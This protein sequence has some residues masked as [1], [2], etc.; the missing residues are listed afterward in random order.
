M[1]ETEMEPGYGVTPEPARH[2]TSRADREAVPT[3]LVVGLTVAVVIAVVTRTWI[4]GPIPAAAALAAGR[5][6]VAIVVALVVVIAAA[7]S[8]VAW[9]ELAPD[10]LGAFQGWGTV[11]EE[12][13][14]FGGATRVLVEL[15]GERYEAWVRGRSGSL[16]AAD[17]RAGDRVHLAGQRMPIDPDRV[18]RVAWQHVVGELEV[19]WLGDALPGG[20]LATASNRV[21]ELVE[22]GASTLAPAHA[23]LARGLVIGDD[24][25]Q[26]PAM[27]ER[28][29]ASG[30][31][32]LMA[33]SGQNVA[34][35][36]AAAGPVLRRAPPFARWLL[37]VLLIGWFV[38]ITRAEPSVL[39]AGLMA[40]L[41]ATAY[42]LGRRQDPVRML[43]VAVTALLLV[44]PLLAWAVGF[45][46][47]VGATF[48]VTAIGPWLAPRLRPLG[49]LA[50][51]VAITLGAQAGVAAPSLLVFGRLSL[52]GTVANLLAVPVAG[53]VMLYGLPACLVAGAL[54]VFGPV[55]MAPVGVGVRW[56][57]AVATAGATLEPRPPWSW[58]GWLVLG[59][60]I[61]L[62][63]AGGRASRRA[64][65]DQGSTSC[66]P[67][68]G[69]QADDTAGAG[70]SRSGR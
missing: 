23:A 31:G 56:I 34:L 33:V 50:V 21:R 58:L 47:S 67:R 65:S 64:E 68:I 40:A 43:A 13:R 2:P 14:P 24:R 54:P 62:L 39:R 20:P 6:V 69:L 5:R 32:H 10:Q 41:S 16:R 36:V 29:R 22:R 19:D 37:T 45:W 7:R 70:A 55:V 57:D 30:L 44:D 11:V 59:V 9:S 3:A 35:V 66:P 53:L 4:V 12:P 63:V 42:V 46:L 61:V 15:D 38:V 52:V 17:W 28:F 27:V 1:V 25:D 49:R 8:D 18:S 48:G 60:A 26:P 51:P